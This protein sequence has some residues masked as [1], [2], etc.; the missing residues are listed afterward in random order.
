M[1]QPGILVSFSEIKQDGEAIHFV[2]LSGRFL[3]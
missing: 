3:S 2:S 1:L